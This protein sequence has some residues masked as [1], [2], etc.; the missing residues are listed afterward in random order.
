MKSV[1]GFFFLSKLIINQNKGP[2]PEGFSGQ[3]QDLL[4]YTGGRVGER[5]TVHYIGLFER[6][7]E[8][9]YYIGR[10]EADKRVRVNQYL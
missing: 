10:C 1:V 5:E 6:G 8:A 3:V 9:A 2:H 7:G 4:M